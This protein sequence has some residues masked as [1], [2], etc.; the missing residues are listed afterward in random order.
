MTDPLFFSFL[1]LLSIV[2]HFYLKLN[3][4]YLNNLSGSKIYFERIKSKLQNNEKLTL[5][6]RANIFYNKVS[7]LLIAVSLRIGLIL[8]IFGIVLRVILKIKG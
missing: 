4:K 6:E 8:I 5:R 7:D 1:G 3:L 2:F